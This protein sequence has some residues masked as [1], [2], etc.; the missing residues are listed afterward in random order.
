M[1]D[2]RSSP[3]SSVCP[4]SGTPH[5]RDSVYGAFRWIYQDVATFTLYE[6]GAGGKGFV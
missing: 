4:R 5:V 6:D 2:R 1:P 3:V